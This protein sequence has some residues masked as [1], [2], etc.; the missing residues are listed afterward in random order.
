MSAVYICHSTLIAYYTPFP[1]LPS[2]FYWLHLSSQET[3]SADT[4]TPKRTNVFIFG[5]SLLFIL[6]KLALYKLLLLILLLLRYHKIPKHFIDCIGYLYCNFHSSAVTESYHTPF[7]PV[8]RGVPSE[9]LPIPLLLNM[10]YSTW[11]YSISKFLNPKYWFQF[12]DDAAI[13]TGLQ[14]E[15]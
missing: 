11:L 6:Y 3:L 13:T 4:C 7:L 1:P 8:Q 5:S 9:G 15:N 2:I 12:A 10:V 14:N